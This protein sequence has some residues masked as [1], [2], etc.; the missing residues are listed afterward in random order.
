MNHS[1]DYSFAVAGLEPLGKAHEDGEAGW[2]AALRCC[3]RM[4]KG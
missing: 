3:S 2:L 1:G 4:R